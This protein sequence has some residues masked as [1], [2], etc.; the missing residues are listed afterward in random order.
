V[1]LLAVGVVVLASV[2][3]SI[4]RS[5]GGDAVDRVRMLETALS[6]TI[7]LAAVLITMRIMLLMTTARVTNAMSSYVDMTAVASDFALALRQTNKVTMPGYVGESMGVPLT[8][9]PGIKQFGTVA[10]AMMVLV[11]GCFLLGYVARA[12]TI[13]KL[14][15]HA[16]R[17]HAEAKSWQQKFAAEA[18]KR[19]AEPKQPATEEKSSENGAEAE[20][21]PGA[22]TG[23]AEVAANE[24]AP[25]ENAIAAA[26]TTPGEDATAA[27]ATPDI[28]AR[29]SQRT[30]EFKV[31]GRERFPP[32][33]LEIHDTA[34]VRAGMEVWASAGLTWY[35]SKVVRV[36][37]RMIRIRFPTSAR[38]P[39]RRL[40][41]THVR[42]PADDDGGASQ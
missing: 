36:E 5:Q 34:D 1:A 11:A 22:A 7:T 13:G 37:S 27:S 18:Q 29:A 23:A 8:P 19:L 35:R 12:S 21:A 28:Q 16:G 17:M 6:A 4:L 10:A 41:V 14:K 40:P 26:E 15:Q 31:F 24:H 2:G 38:L 25:L 33:S 39:E 32:R 3:I 20:A 30:E 42:L 9:D